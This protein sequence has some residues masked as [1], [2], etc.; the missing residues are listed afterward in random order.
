ATRVRKAEARESADRVLTRPIALLGR[1]RKAQ[2]GHRG[3]PIARRDRPVSEARTM[4]RCLINL[5][6]AAQLHRSRIA[7]RN[8]E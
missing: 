6:N 7:Q 2:H 5:C 3:S 4:P 1:A 8:R